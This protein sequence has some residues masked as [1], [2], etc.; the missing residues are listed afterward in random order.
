MLHLS[1]E[2]LDVS[3]M[4]WSVKCL[5]MTYFMVHTDEVNYHLRELAT[6]TPLSTAPRYVKKAGKNNLPSPC[7][8]L[9][10]EMGLYPMNVICRGAPVLGAPGLQLARLQLR[11]MYRL[12]MTK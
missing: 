4:R 1:I 10:L 3:H 9:S 5:S 7:G 12:D 11:H 2:I 6:M 8:S